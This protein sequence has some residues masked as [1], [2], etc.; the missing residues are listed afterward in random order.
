M[1]TAKRKL[2]LIA[3][4]SRKVRTKGLLPAI[5]RYDGVTYRVIRKAMREGY[6]PPNVEIK[7]LSAKFGLI[8]S[9]TRIP[10][11]DRRM[12]KERAIEIRPQVL[13]NLEKVFQGN[14]YSDVFVNMGK[15]Y[16]LATNG[17]HDMVRHNVRVISARG[18]IGSKAKHMKQ[19]LLSTDQAQ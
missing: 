8:D 5:E 3:C 18:G 16:L 12:D 19:W 6:F 1:S 2:L 14:E 4:S 11:Y 17:W 7:I 15:T 13:D 9:E 10:Y